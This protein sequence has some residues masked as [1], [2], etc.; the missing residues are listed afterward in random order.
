VHILQ[1]FAAAK[2]GRYSC[3]SVTAEMGA[4]R[5]VVEILMGFRKLLKSIGVNVKPGNQG[6]VQ[7]ITLICSP[8]KKRHVAVA[9]SPSS[10]MGSPWAI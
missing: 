5:T 4:G 2:R 7:N 6:Q 1:E 10:G 3:S 9:H 8:L